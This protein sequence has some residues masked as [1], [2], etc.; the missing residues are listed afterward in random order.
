MTTKPPMLSLPIPAIELRIL[1]IRDQRVM[2]DSDL[3]E[4]YGVP[5]KRLNE[6]VSRNLGRFPE[7]FM[8][9]LTADEA[10]LL[11]SQIAT[12][13]KPHGKGGRRNLPRV[14]TEHGVL[15]AAN[16]LK[17]DRAVSVSVRIIKAF[18]RMRS[19]MLAAPDLAKKIAEIEARLTGCEDQQRLFHDLVLP[20]LTI[21]MP[22]RPRRIGFKT[23]KEE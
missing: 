20:L 5:T 19:A 23:K 18:V 7:E 2:L 3:A 22:A 15:M 10:S 8:F 14:F 1:T 12:S 17:S 9:T 16:V 6:Q 11:R 4:L 13:E 21:D